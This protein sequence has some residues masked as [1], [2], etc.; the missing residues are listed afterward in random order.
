MDINVTDPNVLS[1]YGVING[2]QPHSCSVGWDGN[3]C[4][5][6]TLCSALPDQDTYTISVGTEVK[7]SAGYALAGDRNI[8]ITA[9]KGDVNSSRAVNSQDMLAIRVRIGESVGCSNARYEVNCSGALN[10]QDML[11]VRT[12]ASHVAPQC[13]EK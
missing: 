6:I 10:S 1:I 12:N 13:P 11:A 4:M 8:C 9:L 3:T 5:I 7:S 2:T